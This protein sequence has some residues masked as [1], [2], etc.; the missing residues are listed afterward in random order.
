MY[1]WRKRAGARWLRENIATLSDHA[2]FSLAITERPGSTRALLTICCRTAGLAKKLVTEFGGTAERLRPDW[3]RRFAEQNKAAPLRIG[4]RLVVISAPTREKLSAPGIIIPA[5]AAFG[6]GSHATTAMC[7]RLLERVTRRWPDGWRMLDCGM[8]SGIL[9]IAA[10]YFGANRLVAID[11]DPVASVTA[12]RNARANGVG[13][14]SV[15]TGDVLQ[16]KLSGKFHIIAANLFSELLIKALPRWR[17][18]LASESHLIL[19]GILRMQEPEVVRALRRNH[20]IVAETRRR[21]KWI[22]LLAHPQKGS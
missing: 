17:P 21:G 19:S 7:L 5:E 4:S 13:D 6:T 11:N 22:A 16:Q 20:F 3:L 1:I 8:G 12:M 2:G 10:A 15:L 14:L 18:Y 9:A